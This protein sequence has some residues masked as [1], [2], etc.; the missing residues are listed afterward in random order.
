MGVKYLTRLAERFNG[1]ME[2][3][4]ASYN[5]GPNN[6]DEWLKRNPNRSDSLLWNDL[7]PYMETRDYV[8]GILR[9]TYFYYRL[10]HDEAAP[11]ENEQASKGNIY[12]SAMIKELLSKSI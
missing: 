11:S 6:V 10:Y 5:A 7:I 1:D 4:L 8:V 2:L 12:Q 3:V 9:N